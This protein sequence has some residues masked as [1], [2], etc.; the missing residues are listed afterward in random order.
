MR[1][2]RSWLV[3]ILSGIVVLS[4]A[5]ESF[6][7]TINLNSASLSATG[8]NLFPG[9]GAG[10]SATPDL[11]HTGSASTYAGSLTLSVGVSQ[12]FVF[13]AAWVI[14]ADTN[15]GTAFTA[16]TV[17]VVTPINVNFATA[18]GSANVSFAQSFNLRDTV[19]ATNGRY[20]AS[21]SAAQNFLVGQNSF[22]ANFQGL[23]N[24]NFAY[25]AG[26][27]TSA[28]ID[29]TVTITYNGLIPEPA[30]LALFGLGLAPITVAIRRRRK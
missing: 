20:S 15:G 16:N 27:F 24:T 8:V 6:A 21:A 4:V 2:N 17:G 10:A 29:A 28:P 23:S 30:T 5:G 7:Q 3:G 11:T 19:T 9:S 25:A 1:T 13:P 12:S 14:Q 22:T 18:A 26:T